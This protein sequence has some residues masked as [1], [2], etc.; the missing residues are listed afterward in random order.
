LL[1]C[2]WQ[3]Q[4]AGGERVSR[5]G[6]EQQSECASHDHQNWVNLTQDRPTFTHPCQLHLFKSNS[7]QGSEKPV[8]FSKNP[9]HWV[10]EDYIGFWALLDFFGIFYLNE[11]LG[12]LLVDLA[13]RLS[14]YLDSPVL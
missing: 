1:H 4:D 10:L 13:H 3:V 12:S 8:F 9:T 14:F 7:R 6:Q 5:S 11:Q 2:S